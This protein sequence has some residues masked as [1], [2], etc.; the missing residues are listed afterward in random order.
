VKGPFEEK[1]Y[2]TT[3]GA[4]KQGERRNGDGKGKRLMQSAQRLLGSA[5]K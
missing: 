1:K 5:E 2:L 3:E 4:E